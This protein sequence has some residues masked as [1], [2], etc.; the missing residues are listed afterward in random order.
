MTERVAIQKDFPPV[1][2]LS[3]PGSWAQRRECEDSGQ[4]TA[5]DVSWIGAI[6]PTM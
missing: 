5:E 2:C 1:E 6:A 4:P 3:S